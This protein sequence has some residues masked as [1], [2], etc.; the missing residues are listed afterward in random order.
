MFKR[1]VKQGKQKFYFKK[2]LGCIS[3]HHFY[4][5]YHRHNLLFTIKHIIILNKKIGFD[6]DQ[7]LL[8][9]GTN[10]LER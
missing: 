8:I 2:W 6:K 1:T 3:I 4:H 10:T 9:Q 5:S 7:V